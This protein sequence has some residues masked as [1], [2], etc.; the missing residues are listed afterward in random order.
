MENRNE[1]EQGDIVVARYDWNDITKRPFEFLYE[2]GYYSKV[3]GKCVVYNHGE[4]NM[5]DSHAFDVAEIRLASEEDKEKCYW[6]N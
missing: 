1:F 6:G 5:Q 3:E 2:F 4:C